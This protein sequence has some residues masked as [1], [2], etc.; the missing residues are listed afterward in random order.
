MKTVNL[1]NKLIEA[2]F[3]DVEVI[4]K[5]VKVN[6]GNMAKDWEKTYFVSERAYFDDMKLNLLNFA[7][8]HGTHA[9]RESGYFII[10]GE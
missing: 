3:N 6:I 4:G 9:K 8:L 2:G 10:Y 1:K 5:D 7:S